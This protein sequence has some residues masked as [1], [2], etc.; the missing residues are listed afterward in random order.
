MSA[1]KG[2]LLDLD[3]T[4]IDA[5]PPIVRAMKKTL[6]EFNL[7]D[8]SEHAIRRHTGR[9]DC[10]MATLFGDNKKEATQRFIAIHDETYLHHIDALPG[11]E[12]LLNW[13][14]DQQIPM[15]VVTSKGQ[16]RAQAQLEKLGWLERFACIIGKLEGR[17]AKPNPE[18][19]LL[20]CDNM[21]LPIKDMIM[22]GDGEA[23]MQA[24]QRAGCLAVGL[25]SSFSDKELEQA[26]ANH[27][28]SSLDEVL[29]WLK[30]QIR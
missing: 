24:A 28:F 26:G 5:F 21:G 9:G 10:S 22:V 6:H 29:L 14:E 7:P 3:G 11:A 17:A 1:I 12:S 16:H 2:V 30:T 13:L 25:S 27:C 4:L 20:A 23:D 15:A 18:P 19:L 8:M